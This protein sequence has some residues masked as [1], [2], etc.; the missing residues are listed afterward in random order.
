MATRM[1][2]TSKLEMNRGVFPTVEAFFLENGRPLLFVLA[3][4]LLS[5]G[6]EVFNFNFSI[7]E[8]VQATRPHQGWL[9]L[10]R[11]GMYLVNILFL[12]YT[13]IP[14]VPIS[15]A[16]LL[17]AVAAVLALRMVERGNGYP[18]YVFPA[19]IVTF[20][21]LAFNLSFAN[22]AAGIGFGILSAVI[23][24][25]L[26]ARDPPR[27]KVLGVVLLSFSV[28]VYQS[29]LFITV[30]LLS[31]HQLTLLLEDSTYRPSQ[32]VRTL[33][34]H[35]VALLSGVA[36]YA[37]VHKSVMLLTTTTTYDYITDY[38]APDAI[39]HQPWWVLSRL[40]DS[41]RV[42]YLGRGGF[43]IEQLWLVPAVLILSGL[44]V[45]RRLWASNRRPWESAAVALFALLVLLVPFALHP[46]TGG[47]LPVRTLLSLPFVMALLMWMSFRYGTL[48]TRRLSVVMSALLIVNYSTINNRHLNAT[49]FA[50][51][52]DRQLGGALIHRINESLATEGPA[53]CIEV[54]GLWTHPENE[55]IR[56]TSTFG[57]SFFEWD[58]GNPFRIA[59]FLR[60]LG[61]PPHLTPCSVERRQQ[62]I[63]HAQSMSNWP[64]QQSVEVFDGVLIVKLSSYSE[65]QTQLICGESPMP[66]CLEKARR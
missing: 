33:A 6:F 7:D 25:R 16:L 64:L 47:V 36:L 12:R 17:N 20:P 34:Q 66:V 32:A 24:A 1:S 60:T 51:E 57:A 62:L 41:M 23:A 46:F 22:N 50:L 56:K 14:V 65:R 19:L 52:A 26:L 37:L 58:Q 29:L 43:Y 61:L 40:L 53:R 48:N 45:G 15:I 4:S 13:A 2:M 30:G 8:E 63:E 31:F 44:V 39:V 5:Y 55:F 9:Q 42:A 11:W 35:A 10:G 28:A 3:A 38:L 54:V 21:T 27:S 59:P 49:A 18:I